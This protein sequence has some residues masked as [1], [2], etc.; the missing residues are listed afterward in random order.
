MRR[1]HETR[2]TWWNSDYHWVALL[3][4]NG[5]VFVYC[6]S[7][8]TLL[9]DQNQCILI[10]IMIIRVYWWCL[11]F[12]LGLK[13]IHNVS[14]EKKQL[15]KRKNQPWTY[16]PAAYPNETASRNVKMGIRFCA[17]AVNK[18]DVNHNPARNSCCEPTILHHHH[19]HSVI[20]HSLPALQIS[21]P[22]PQNSSFMC[23][24]NYKASQ[25][26]ES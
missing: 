14:N 15:L 1:A 26:A 23:S 21:S 16:G 22:A 12:T 10:M 7:N 17:T 11:S 19:P 4:F 6:F 9:N 5:N 25:V 2:K 20:S 13:G 18:G 8:L 3:V 24:G